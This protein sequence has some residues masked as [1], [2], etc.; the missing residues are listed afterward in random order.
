MD[1]SMEDIRGYG[2]YFF[3]VS[4]L[5]PELVIDV[6][7]GSK[8]MGANLILWDYTGTENQRFRLN[9]KGFIESLHSGFV[10]DVSGGAFAGKDIIQWELH[11]GENQ[12]WKLY[13]DGSIRL[14]GKPELCIDVVHGAKERGTKLCAWTY[15]GGLNQK[16][17]L[18]VINAPIA[19]HTLQITFDGKV[20]TQQYSQLTSL[21]DLTLDTVICHLNNSERVI[22]HEELLNHENIPSNVRI[23][24]YETSMHYDGA[25]FDEVHSNLKK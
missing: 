10:I 9:S 11:E 20:L 5:N 22:V 8:E 6:N 4:A 15:H 17:R 3:I 2:S 1:F 19:L 21:I 25:T 18:I 13:P 7:G 23:G 24:P 16:W 14:M 12:R